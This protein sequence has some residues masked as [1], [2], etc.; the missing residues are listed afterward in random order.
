MTHWRKSRN[1][2][3]RR[4]E[5][6]WTGCGRQGI[7]RYSQSRTE[8]VVEGQECG[9]G[10]ECSVEKRVPEVRQ[11]EFALK[12]KVKVLYKGAAAES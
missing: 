5:S 9:V 12:K 6:V 8:G 3:S 1:R 7:F 10:W 11:E 2:S 4:I